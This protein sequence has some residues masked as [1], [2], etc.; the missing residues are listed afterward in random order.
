MSQL[1]T[2]HIQTRTLSVEVGTSW[3]DSQMQTYG[4]VDVV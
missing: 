4:D 2:R 3:T 1:K